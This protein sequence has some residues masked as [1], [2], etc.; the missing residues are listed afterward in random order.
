M[1]KHQSCGKCRS[2]QCSCK[3]RSRGNLALHATTHVL[4]LGGASDPVMVNVYNYVE[5]RRLEL[6]KVLLTMG[7]P[8]RA[9][10]SET[11][12]VPF[13]LLTLLQGPG[14]INFNLLPYT[15]GIPDP[16]L[17]QIVETWDATGA[18]ADLPFDVGVFVTDDRVP[19]DTF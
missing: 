10:F 9:P 5:V 18:P 1:R 7:S 13:G 8:I 11:P 3:P 19:P 6:G 4:Y 14:M 2:P 15:A 17:Q 16:T 12:I